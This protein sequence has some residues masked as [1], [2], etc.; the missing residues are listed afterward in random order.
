MFTKVKKNSIEINILNS[1]DLSN[2]VNNHKEHKN[3]IHQNDFKA[4]PGQ[5]LIIPSSDGHIEKIL[6]GRSDSN[7]VYRDFFCYKLSKCLPNKSYHFSNL[8]EGSTLPYLSWALG[9]YSYNSS[10][11]NNSK[12]Y[13][14]EKISTEV[15][16]LVKS[17][18]F[19]MDL[20]NHQ[21][22]VLTT[23][24]FAKNIR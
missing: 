6:V 8:E 11:K 19:T 5:F 12:L 15:Q 22:N 1:H 21:A 9:C 13:L 3:W 24:N 20:I 4:S 18:F 2:F 7:D 14:P 16:N 17:I 10:P 23:E